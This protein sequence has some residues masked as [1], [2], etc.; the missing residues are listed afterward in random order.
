[1]AMATFD[2]TLQTYKFSSK[3]LFYDA[4]GCN[5]STLKLGTEALVDY[6]RKGICLP[7]DPGLIYPFTPMEKRPLNRT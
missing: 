2:M 5:T 1:M 7:C 4:D 3:I 6:L